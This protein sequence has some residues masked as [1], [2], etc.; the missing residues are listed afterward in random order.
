MHWKYLLLKNSGQTGQEQAFHHFEYF[1]I[2]YLSIF[3]FR[4]INKHDRIEK[5]TL[6]AMN[7]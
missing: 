1:G 4:W 6:Q 3:F 2:L 5:L 7:E